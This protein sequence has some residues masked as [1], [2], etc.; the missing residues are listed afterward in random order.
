MAPTQKIYTALG[1]MSGTSLDGIDVA[2][3]Q[4]DGHHRVIT[5]PAETF[6]YAPGFI[7]TL[8]KTLGQKNPHTPAMKK[9]ERQMT[10]LHAKAVKKFCLKNNI[11]LQNIDVIGFHG[12]TIFHAPQHFITLQI[13]DGALLARETQCRVVNQFRGD[14][15]KAGGHGAPLVP[16]F[17]AALAHPLPKPLAVVN[18]GGVSNITWLAHENTLAACDC[19]PGNALIN[20]WLHSHNA[21]AFDD[22]GTFAARGSIDWA[23]VHRFLADDFFA[24]PAPKSLDRDHFKT[25]MPH[26]LDLADGA[27]TLTA[28]TA[29]AIART[30]LKNPP[31]VI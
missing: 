13:G 14:D 15:V 4:T 25:Y 8:R 29:A 12:Q 11:L 7:N 26:H 9:I 2:W 16:V 23:H 20:D 22:K 10:W 1:L 6:A 28:M 5:G 19:G 17:H 24:R 30:L 21:G 31:I 3:L 18:V 27:A